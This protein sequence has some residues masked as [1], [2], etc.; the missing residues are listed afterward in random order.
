MQ[1]AELS[2][3]KYAEKQVSMKSIERILGYFFKAFT[4]PQVR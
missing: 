3:Q 2:V 1:R 4:L